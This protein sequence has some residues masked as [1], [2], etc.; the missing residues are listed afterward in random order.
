MNFTI[1]I[2]TYKRDDDLKECLESIKKNSKFNNEVIVLYDINDTTKKICD[3]Y[4]AKSVFDNARKNGKKVKS[5][6]G[7]LNEGLN[8]ATNDYVMYL[9]D[10]CLVQPEWDRIASDYFSKD[11]KIG[12]LILRTYG[13]GLV[14]EFRIGYQGGLFEGIPCANYAIINKRC[15][16]FF[17]EK[18]QWYYGDA[19]IALQFAADDNFHIECTSEDM[20]IHNHKIDENRK[21]HDSNR[22]GNLK[23]E[24]YFTSKWANY[25]PVD[26][27]KVKKSSK[28]NSFKYNIIFLFKYCHLRLWLIAKKLKGKNK[29]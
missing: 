24:W 25:K 17:D 14:P 26:K 3:E 28:I 7:I 21:E 8:N 20:I 18:I 13:I 29:S 16:H 12:L 6:W 11:E 10:D 2:P 5:L 15:N 27:N 9:N 22:I 19:D 4:G 1:I 23:D